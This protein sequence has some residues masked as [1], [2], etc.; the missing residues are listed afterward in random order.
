MSY[1]LSLIMKH[2]KDETLEESGVID[3]PFD[4]ELFCLEN[5]KERFTREIDN[6]IMISLLETEIKEL[7]FRLEGLE[8]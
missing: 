8:K 6:D 3:L 2:W 1:T 5:D 7:K 4:I